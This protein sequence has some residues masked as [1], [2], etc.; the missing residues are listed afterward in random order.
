M[1]QMARPETLVVAD[2]RV[3]EVGSAFWPE[4]PRWR[5]T[6]CSVGGATLNHL[7]ELADARITAATKMIVVFGL[8]CDLT[9]RP[10]LP[11]GKFGLARCVAPNVEELQATIATYDQ[12]WRD[13]WGLTVLW[14]VPYVMNFLNYNRRRS[15]LLGYGRLSK[16]QEVEAQSSEQCMMAAV[17]TLADSLREKRCL[18][19]EL[20]TVCDPGELTGTGIGARS[21]CVHLPE[22]T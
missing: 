7:L 14:T 4:L 6:L 19:V 9:K 2:S 3:R 8:Q 11:G 17:R 20:S 10:E 12:I 5:L 16:M 18:V 13:T 22:S 1:F 15:Q 21:D